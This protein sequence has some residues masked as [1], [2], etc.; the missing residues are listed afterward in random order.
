MFEQFLFN[1]IEIS[2]IF[3]FGCLGEILIEK[4]GHLNLGIPGTMCVGAAG[5]CFGVKLAMNMAQ[6]GFLVILF[7][8]I[9]TCVFAGLMGLLYAFLTVTLR[10]NQNVT[11]LAMTIFGTGFASY[12]LN[13]VVLSNDL[14]S[15]LLSRA[16]QK[17]FLYHLP[18]FDK[19]G[20]F[21]HLFFAHG[22]LTYLAI[23][24]AVVFAYML[25]RTRVG[26]NLRA[27][28]ESPAT[29]DATGINVTKYKYSFIL[30]G[31]AVA[32]LGGLTYVM[33]EMSG[34]V[35]ATVATTIQEFGWLAIA[36]VIFTVWKPAVAVLGSIVFGG[37][38]IVQSYITGISFL[39]MKLLPLIPY[40]VTIIVLII[41]S[42]I[43]SK[44]VQAPQSLGVPYFR[45]ER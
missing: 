12:F 45:E 27:I 9:F 26:L 37:L 38:Y 22:T 31:S 18:I 33:Q 41:T 8:V 39:Q 1:A 5:G 32:G 42:V 24:L 28:G 21:G 14:S 25:K 4:A 2:V 36:L 19:M 6:N 43:G 34:I 35:G 11:G 15:T 13:G 7:A 30:I 29:A 3:L 16:G 10:V 40:V 20:W 23:L 17:F 44:E